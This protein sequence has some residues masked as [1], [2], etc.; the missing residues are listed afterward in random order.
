MTR[1]S[2]WKQGKLEEHG[3]PVGVPTPADVERRASELALIAGRSEVTRE[4]REAARVELRNGNLPATLVE[5][6]DGNMQSLSR[7]P[8]DPATDR[9]HQTPE[10]MESDE[11]EV[12]ERLALE[13]VEEAQH[14]QMVQSRQSEPP[15]ETNVDR[16]TQRDG[17]AASPPAGAT[18]RRR[19]RT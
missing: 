12:C 6:A 3:K 1:I 7:D 8:S 15:V 9:G 18:K 4:D 14:E 2:Q 10:Y 16:G 13:G 17:T 19:R 5:D 11:Q